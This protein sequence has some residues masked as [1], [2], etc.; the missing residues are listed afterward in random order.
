MNTKTKHG[1]RRLL[2]MLL[3]VISVMGMIDVT[4]FAGQEDGYKANTE[5]LL[6]LD[7]EEMKNR[8]HQREE[9]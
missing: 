9:K 1:C 6:N 7:R 5:R 8:E 3:V 2:A 4:A